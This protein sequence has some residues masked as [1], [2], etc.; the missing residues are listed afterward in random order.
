MLVVFLNLHH[1]VKTVQVKLHEKAG[2]YTWARMPSGPNYC[3]PVVA[4]NF[5]LFCR[6]IDLRFA[7]RTSKELYIVYWGGGGL[8][9]ACLCLR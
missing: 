9:E 2:K 4:G 8:L 7:Y 6:H 5:T 1:I 3:L